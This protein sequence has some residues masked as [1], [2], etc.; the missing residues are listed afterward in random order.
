ML[1]QGFN[2][3]G[4]CTL[5]PKQLPSVRVMARRGCDLDR[6]AAK[7]IGDKKAMP[8]DKRDAIAE[9]TD[10]IDGEALNHAARR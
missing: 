10:M 1:A 2:A 9:M 7:R 3:L 5:D 6:L 8:F 4:A